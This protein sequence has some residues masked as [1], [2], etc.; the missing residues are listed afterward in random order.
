MNEEYYSRINSEYYSYYSSVA[1]KL[2][3][4]FNVNV[5]INKQDQLCKNYDNNFN[6]SNKFDYEKELLNFYKSIIRLHDVNYY[7]GPICTTK[8][9]KLFK[10]KQNGSFLLRDSTHKNYLLT[11]TFKAND[12]VYHIRMEHF[13]NGKFSFHQDF[14]SFIEANSIVDFMNEVVKK[15]KEGHLFLISPR[16]NGKHFYY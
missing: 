4:D 15:S 8:A 6:D 1:S 14:D 3:K 9:E 2:S 13:A 11:L 12:S 10:N 16:N 5:N 7:W